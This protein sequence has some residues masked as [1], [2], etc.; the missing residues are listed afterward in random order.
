MDERGHWD[1]VFAPALYAGLHL[2]VTGWYRGRCR[3]ACVWCAGEPHEPL[4]YSQAVD[5]SRT[6]ACETE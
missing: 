2:R 3:V 4:T 5:W 1:L 6:H